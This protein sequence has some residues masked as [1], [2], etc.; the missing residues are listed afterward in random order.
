MKRLKNRF[1]SK[2]SEWIVLLIFFLLSLKVLNWFEYPYI[3]ISGDIR[4]PLMPEAFAKHALYM[5]NEIDLGIPSIYVPRILNPL[6]FFIICSQILGINA[7]SSQIIATF[8]IYFLTSTLMYFYVK[9]ILNNDTITPF[10]AAIFFTSNTYLI[11]DRE[12]TA[13]GFLNIAL[14]ILPC[15]VALSRGIR[16]KSYRTLIISSLLFNLTYGTYP[17]YRPLLICLI[18]L[19]ITYLFFVKKIKIKL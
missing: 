13:I 16:K 19:A 1:I 9:Q 2:F 6:Y 7:Y 15:L 4:P 10:I 12:Q 11:C 5:W 18:S 14:M 17:N 3:I 8:L